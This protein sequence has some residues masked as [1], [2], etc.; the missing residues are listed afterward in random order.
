MISKLLSVQPNLPYKISCITGS[1]EIPL[2]SLDVSI[3][4]RSYLVSREIGSEMLGAEALQVLDVILVGGSQQ[5]VTLLSQILQPAAVYELDHVADHAEVQVL[6]VDLVVI[7]HVVRK[8]IA[9]HGGPGAQNGLTIIVNKTKR[10][11]KFSPS[12]LRS[13]IREL[14]KSHETLDRPQRHLKES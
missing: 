2:I 1:S 14:K 3:S 7:T 12:V 13:K 9:E 8:H 10:S 5:E 11:T 6:D 4:C